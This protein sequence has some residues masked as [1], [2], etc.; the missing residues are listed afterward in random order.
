M[1]TLVKAITPP[2]VQLPWNA[3]DGML[4]SSTAYLTFML[5]IL[6]IRGPGFQVSDFESNRIIGERQFLGAQTVMN[7]ALSDVN[8]SIKSVHTYVAM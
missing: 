3:M 4:L 5:H 1:A 8:G 2:V 6:L 7:G